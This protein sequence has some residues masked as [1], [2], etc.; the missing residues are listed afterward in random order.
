MF[1]QIDQEED[2]EVYV[3]EPIIKHNTSL[4]LAISRDKKGGGVLK[5][6]PLWEKLLFFLNWKKKGIPTAIKL[7]GGVGKAL[8]ALPL[9]EKKKILVLL[10]PLPLFFSFF[11]PNL[12]F[13]FPIS[14]LSIYL[15]VIPSP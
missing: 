2:G 4:Y 12:Y 8:M 7:K 14:L 3:R 13:T 1:L 15:Y 11:L 5:G 10:L 9:K 6:R